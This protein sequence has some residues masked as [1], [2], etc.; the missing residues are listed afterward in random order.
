[1]ALFCQ[2]TSMSLRMPP[3]PH[4]SNKLSSKP[5]SIQNAKN[6]NV[7]LK[8]EDGESNTD[9]EEIL[10]YARTRA[11]VRN[12]DPTMLQN[13]NIGMDQQSSLFGTIR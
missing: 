3:Q 7:S 11:T 4:I 5:E 2:R 13:R 12:Y 1:M 10:L 6:A 8:D 9:H